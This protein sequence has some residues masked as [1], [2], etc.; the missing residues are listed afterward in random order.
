LILKHFLGQRVEFTYPVRPGG[1]FSN[2]TREEE[3]F[4]IPQEVEDS[5]AVCPVLQ[6]IRHLEQNGLRGV[7]SHERTNP[8][9]FPLSL[10]ALA[11]G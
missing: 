9:S 4:S 6:G 1:S 5:S 3:I 8:S 10:S 7:G 2:G 11:Q